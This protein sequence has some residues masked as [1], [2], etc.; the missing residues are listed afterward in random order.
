[1]KKITLLILMGIAFLRISAQ[2]EELALTPPMGW[3]SWDC[4]GMDITEEQLKATADY[5]AKHLKEYGWEY[6]VLDMGWNYGEG[7][8]T[9]NFRMEKPPQVMDEYG[10]LI[11]SLKK[12]PSAA[13]GHGLK[14]LADYV[15]SLGLK[16]GIH[17]MRGIPWQAVEQNIP[18][19]GT[20]YNARDIATTDNACTWYHG[21]LS[22]DITKPGAQEYYNSLFEIYAEWGVDFIKADD[23]LKRPYHKG[24]IEAI[25]K[26]I[27]NCGRPIVL[28]LSA[29]PIQVHS[30]QHLR[31]NS[32]MWRITGDMWDQWSFV[33][34][35]FTYCREW[36]SF[37]VPNHW[38]DCDMLPFGRLRINGT[39]GMLA[40]SLGIEREETVNEYS[41]LTED[42]KQ[43][44]MGLWAI[45]RS[46]LMMGGDLMDLDPH[47]YELLINREVLAVNQSSVN[48]RE[49]RF[50]EKE[51][52]WIADDPLSGAKYVAMFNL[53][54]KDPAKIRLSFEELG[55]DGEYQVNDL[56]LKQNIGV[57][58][59]SLNIKVNSHGCKIFKLSKQE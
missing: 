3:N 1:M 7:L 21:M 11:P 52:I 57:N 26:A 6:V 46:P 9:N 53:S 36:Q 8:N 54:A 23:I 37:V 19:K 20:G 48:N 24:E 38:P 13:D 56:W 47:T 29:G 55:I 31:S 43:T 27:E 4:F 35:T 51:S 16:F 34:R 28:S 49:L 15:H 33:E 2:I 22:V 59:K 10:R 17:I 5:M 45:F 39:D 44:I 58:K 18:I 14:P 50:N 30:V 12:F 41:R 40:E 32:H 25:R 42:E